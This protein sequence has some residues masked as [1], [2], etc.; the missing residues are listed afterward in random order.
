MDKI[1][2]WIKKN[3][4]NIVAVAIAITLFAVDIITKQVIMKH[5][6][7]PTNENTSIVWIPGFLRISYVLNYKAAFGF[8]FGNDLTNR[9]VYICFASIGFIAL[10]GF[11]IWK[12]KKLK[13]L[14]KICLML[15]ASG[16]L[17]N[18][19]DRIFYGPEYAVVDWIDFYGIWPF[20]FNIADCCVVIGAILMMILLIIEEVKEYLAKKK[21]KENN[22]SENNEEKVLSLEEKKRLEENKKVSE[23]IEKI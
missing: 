6:G 8:G 19:I 13:T 2:N 10:I 4:W 12:N 18:L 11:F 3:V 16:A 21:L 1:I 5:F 17:G 14:Y 9:I 22:S 23:E 15:I 20:V 7:T